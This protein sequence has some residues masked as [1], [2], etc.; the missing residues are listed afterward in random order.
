MQEVRFR[1]RLDDDV[2]TWYL[3]G[4]RREEEGSA[5]IERYLDAIVFLG[6]RVARRWRWLQRGIREVGN[7]GIQWEA[8]R[9][10]GRARNNIKRHSLTSRPEHQASHGYKQTNGGRRLYSR[11]HISGQMERFHGYS[12]YYIVLPRA[13]VHPSTVDAVRVVITRKCA[14]M[15]ACTKHLYSL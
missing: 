1:R 13:S 5:W 10:M 7:L 2:G 15:D 8:H 3:R 9:F 11:L 14:I 12:C 6:E 4:G